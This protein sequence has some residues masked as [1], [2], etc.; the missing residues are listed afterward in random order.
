MKDCIYLNTVHLDTKKNAILAGAKDT[1]SH[2][3]EEVIQKIKKKRVQ[4]NYWT[5][6]NW[7]STKKIHKYLSQQ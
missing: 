2:L 4:S 5:S 1:K 6:N 7:K 3:E